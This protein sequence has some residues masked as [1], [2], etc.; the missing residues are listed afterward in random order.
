MLALPE[1]KC[2]P[3]PLIHAGCSQCECS[4][5]KH[6]SYWH[7]KHKDSVK[8]AKVAAAKDDVGGDVVDEPGPAAPG[9]G[10]DARESE[11]KGEY[12]LKVGEAAGYV[13][14]LMARSETYP[15]GNFNTL[16]AGA[17]ACVL[18]H[19]LVPG[20]CYCIPGLAARPGKEPKL[21]FKQ[22]CHVF[23]SEITFADKTEP[24]CVLGC[25]CGNPRARFMLPYA[26]GSVK[27]GST[28]TMSRFDAICEQMGPPCQHVQALGLCTF[29]ELSDMA[30]IPAIAQL[31][32]PDVKV[33][34]GLHEHGLLDRAV[35]YK[36]ADAGA[37]MSCSKK[38]CIHT[39][40]LQRRIH[41]KPLWPR[42]LAIFAFTPRPTEKP[43]SPLL[44]VF[45]KLRLM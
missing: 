38:I 33:S 18:C 5:S 29:D 31:E 2:K 6:T 20:R 36:T 28:A 12:V 35:C 25:D 30:H 34:V 16:V 13:S 39:T 9:D 1:G 37:C 22:Y 44:S 45:A 10:K 3:V 26:Q 8:K 40:F 21:N 19:N 23:L 41:F 4:C 11:G 32:G 24:V 15:L 17:A 27:P 7:S 42:C 43:G 14:L